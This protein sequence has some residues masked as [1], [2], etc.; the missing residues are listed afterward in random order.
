MIAI[1][2]VLYGSRTTTWN[3]SIK[4]HK[5]TGPKPFILLSS[6]RTGSAFLE[7]C[8]NSNKEIHC[9]GEILLGYGG[10]YNKLPPKLFI[11]IEDLEHYGRLYLVGL[12]FP[13]KSIENTWK[14]SP[15]V[16]HI[17]FR[18]MYNQIKETSELKN[19]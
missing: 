4:M 13:I 7:Q 18:L 19:I 11:N 12:L 14:I 8:L 6:Q 17:G 2:K 15:Y 10:S 9:S 5:T 1:I 16:K 3:P